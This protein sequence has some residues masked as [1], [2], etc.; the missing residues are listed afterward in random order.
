V[1]E[2]E[3]LR[4]GIYRALDALEVGDQ[5]KAA[6]ILLECL[7]S[8]PAAEPFRCRF[9]PARFAWAGALEGHEVRQHP[10]EIAEAEEEIAA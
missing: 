7:E 3:Q 8:P 2:L 10:W 6:L 4:A 1:S 5:A 9:C